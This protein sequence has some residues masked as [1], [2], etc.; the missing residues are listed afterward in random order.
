MK[1]EFDWLIIIWR[2]AVHEVI[3]QCLQFC[4]GG[5]IT[6]WYGLVKICLYLSFAHDYSTPVITAQ[7]VQQLYNIGIG[8]DIAGQ[9]DQLIGIRAIHFSQSESL[10]VSLELREREREAQNDTDN[11]G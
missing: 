7:H 10:S 3:M 2:E 6:S 9:E 8:T 11:I 5:H 4:F 1:I